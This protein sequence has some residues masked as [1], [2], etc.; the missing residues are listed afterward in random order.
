MTRSTY[1]YKTVPVR[2]GF[3]HAPSCEPLGEHLPKDH[4]ASETLCTDRLRSAYEHAICLQTVWSDSRGFLSVMSIG[5]LAGLVQA[6]WNGSEVYAL[7]VA[8]FA[9]DGLWM[10]GILMAAP[11]VFIG[12]VAIV[13]NITMIQNDIFGPVDLPLVFNRKT[14]K[15]YRLSDES[16]CFPVPETFKE[17][18]GYFPRLLAYCR[19]RFKPLPITVTEYDWDR[20]EAE[21]H[22]YQPKPNSQPDFF[23][24]VLRLRVKES[25]ASNY[26]VGF[27]VLDATGANTRERSMALWEYIRRF[28]EEN[29]PA[30]PPGK[31]P[32]PRFPENLW[33][34]VRHTAPNFWFVLLS[35]SLWSTHHLWRHGMAWDSATPMWDLTALVTA[36]FC[37]GWLL[38]VPFNLL[39]HRLGQ[40]VGLP[41][42]LLADAGAP[43]D[44]R[45]AATGAAVARSAGAPP[46][47]GPDEHPR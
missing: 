40:Q 4:R 25:P 6:V 28:M 15:V 38:A 29:G 11:V 44:L 24:H 27:I 2:Q 23:N 14:R 20:L 9:E 5:I 7:F 47:R 34:A 37:N 42:R 10:L 35:G 3:G 17:L 32:A 16:P 39:A 46:S 18:V 22:A 13:G 41:R 36:L 31:S 21:H 30:L 19:I 12:V 1:H 43:L 8:L 33:Q 26:L 45:N